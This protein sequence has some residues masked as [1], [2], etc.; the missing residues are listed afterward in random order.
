MASLAEEDRAIVARIQE[1]MQADEMPA[2]Y[3]EGFPRR[4]AA[5]DSA[6]RDQ[7][8]KSWLGKQSK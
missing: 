8:V 3:V 4:W 6:T 7:I 2:K 5:Y 1:A